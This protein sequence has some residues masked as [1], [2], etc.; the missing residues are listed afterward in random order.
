M[1]ALPVSWTTRFGGVDLTSLESKANSEGAEDYTTTGWGRA[2]HPKV[3]GTPDANGDGIPD[4][5][6]VGTNENQWLFQGGT[7][8]V[9]APIGRDEDGWN[10]F[11]TIG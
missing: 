5:W 7:S 10:T 11:L 6:A 8:A 3:L 1:R 9:G 2:T 4:I